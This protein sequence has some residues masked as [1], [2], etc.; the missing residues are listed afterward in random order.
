M[1]DIHFVILFNGTSNDDTDPH[2]TNIVKMRDGLKS[3]DQQFVI[4][5]DGIGNDKEWRWWLPRLFAEMTG[6]GGGWVMR[7]AHQDLRKIMAQAIKDGKIKAGDT[8]HFSVGGF[9]RGAAIARHFA[10]RLVKRVTHE[11]QNQFKLEVNVKLACE[12][13]FDTVASFGLPINLWLLDKVFGVRNQEIDL[14]WDFHIPA[15]TKA[16][17]AVAADERRNAFTPHLV[18]FKPGETEEFWMA[19]DHST[20]GG[21]HKPPAANDHMADEETLRY[22][23]RRAQQNGLQFKDEFLQKYDI[24]NEALQPLGIIKAPSYQ[25]LPPTQRGPRTIYV[26]ENDKPSQRPPMIAASLIQRMQTD[27]LYRPENVLALKQVDVLKDSGEVES[28]LPAKTALL[29]QSVNPK[30]SRSSPRL[31]AQQAPVPTTSNEVITGKKA[32]KV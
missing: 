8:L 7:H 28:Y 21:G 30:G 10:N 15:G 25:E 24:A 26:K 23:V 12:Y 9:S 1:A 31:A 6:Y 29:W 14:G 3:T 17:H 5:R 11:M 13:L 27:R 19:G 32:A 16:Y 4:Y 2:V 20:I 22:M 18:N